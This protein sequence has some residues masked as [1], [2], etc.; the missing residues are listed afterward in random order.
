MSGWD[1]DVDDV[2]AATEVGNEWAEHDD[3]LGDHDVIVMNAASGMWDDGS[4]RVNMS[5]ELL[6][7]NHAKAFLTISKPASKAEI[8]AMKASG[9]KRV[10]MGKVLNNN[11]FMQLK[12]H[13][14]ITPDQIKEGDKFRM[15]FVR[16]GQ[17]NFVRVI[18]ILPAE[19]IGKDGAATD[20]AP[21]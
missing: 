11:L 10:G 1:V 16:K 2:K 8:E 4:P 14:D 21:F 15:S 9:D 20:D 5:L 18:K 6:T 13:Y 19:A 17:T 7:A 3:R 12:Q